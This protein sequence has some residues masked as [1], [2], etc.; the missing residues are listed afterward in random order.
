MKQLL[1]A[2]FNEAFRIVSAAFFEKITKQ[3][4]SHRSCDLRALISDD[5]R[6]NDG[7]GSVK[8]VNL[9]LKRGKRGEPQPVMI[10]TARLIAYVQTHTHTAARN[11][12][13]SSGENVATTRLEKLVTQPASGEIASTPDFGLSDRDAPKYLCPFAVSCHPQGSTCFSKSMRPK[14]QYGRQYETAKRTRRKEKDAKRT[15]QTGLTACYCHSLKWQRESTR[16]PQF[17]IQ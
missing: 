12:S 2:E 8:L 7:T 1:S 4:C 15:Q 14:R 17:I 10:A 3:P 16:F 6:I 13:F 11:T 9:L 5:V